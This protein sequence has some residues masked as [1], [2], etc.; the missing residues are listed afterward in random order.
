M[1]DELDE[2]LSQED[3]ITPS[4]G[5]VASVMEAVQEDAAI[6]QPIPFPWARAL[7]VL[8]AFVVVVAMLAAVVVQMIRMPQM[9][10]DT[11]NVSS[12]LKSG[13]NFVFQANGGWIALAFL[14]AVF[15]TLFS[16]RLA[17]EK[18]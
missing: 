11:W 18:S 4:L 7:P 10:A 3:E 6:T 12:A 8:A 5:F 2:T 16:I 13:L 9:I 17:S 14:L 15:S 1:R